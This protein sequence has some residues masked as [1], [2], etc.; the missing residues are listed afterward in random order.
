MRVLIACEFS[1]VVRE[2]FRARGH[3]AWSC[4][5][6]PAEDG[7]KFHFQTDCEHLLFDYWDLLIAHPPCT[8]LSL[9]GIRW[10]KDH[11]VKRATKPPRWHDG[12]Q[13]RAQQS[14]AAEFFRTLL[15]CNIPMRC[16]ENPMSMASTLVSK[17]NQIIHP[18]QFG[19]MEQK[20]TWLWLRNLPKL[21]HTKNVR[22]EM[23]KLPKNERERIHHMPPGPE[24]E[25]LRSV[26]YSGI[27]E[28][29]ADQWGRLDPARVTMEDP[30][31]N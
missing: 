23:M 16:L 4:D 29:M 18:W 20:Q 15:N 17:R 11:W 22:A 30:F 3:D 8:H 24:R 10:M 7:S 2:A 19:H 21:K 25:R 9:S 27:A 26:T 12:T 6:R 28:A 13:K 14:E 1:G 5:L 31:F